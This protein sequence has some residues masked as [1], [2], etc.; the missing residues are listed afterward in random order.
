MDRITAEKVFSEIIPGWANLMFR[1]PAIEEMAIKRASVCRDCEFLNHFVSS[2]KW[3][4]KC[5]RCGCPII[6]KVRSVHSDCP[7]KKW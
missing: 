1:D 6:A 3:G 5:T 7:E 2:A 4:K